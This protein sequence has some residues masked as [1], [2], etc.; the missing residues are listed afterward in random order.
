MSL[1]PGLTTIHPLAAMPSPPT[2]S[3]PTKLVDAQPWGRN[4]YLAD[5]CIPFCAASVTIW[6]HW[7]PASIEIH[8]SGCSAASVVIGSVTVGADASIVSLTYSTR[9]FRT[10]EEARAALNEAS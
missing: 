6:V 5:D 3:L 10:V 4:R 8:T 9:S 1:M 7:A 2:L